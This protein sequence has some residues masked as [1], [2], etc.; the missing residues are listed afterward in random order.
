M[1][2]PQRSERIASGAEE[3][4]EDVQF[5]LGG[6]LYGESS[7]WPILR[8]GL[9]APGYTLGDALNVKRGADR[10]ARAMELDLEP[11]PLEGEIERVQVP[12]FFF[13]G[14]HDLNT[15]SALA[16]AYLERLEAPLREALW[17][18]RAAHFPFFEEPA[19]FLAELRRVHQAA[20]AWRAGG[21]R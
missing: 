13:L 4:T 8:T 19:R 3:V 11:R 14:R 20:M 6:E 9:F 12:V 7:F 18:E 21:E 15:P 17:F 1:G 10:V 2:D 5:A 16:A